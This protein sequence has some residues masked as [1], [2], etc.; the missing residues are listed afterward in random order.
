MSHT[1]GHGESASSTSSRQPVQAATEMAF[2][3]SKKT[4]W[5]TTALLFAVLIFFQF[6]GWGLIARLQAAGSGDTIY[7]S[8]SYQGSIGGVS[9]TRDDVI[10][11]DVAADSWSMYFDGSDVGVPTDADVIGFHKLA[12]G[13]L[14][15][16][17]LEDGIML[18]DVGYVD[19]SDIVRFIPT[20]LG[21]TTSGS[22]EMYFDGSDVGLTAPD[23]YEDLRAV[24]ID[25]ATG[26]IYLKP[27]WTFSVQG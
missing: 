1:I 10:F 26:N 21:D 24:W 23:D 16:T 7:L 25:P 2:L 8:T 19:G 4:V 13:S 20:S 17:F 11:Y 9:F 27:K 5:I 12:D 18:P 15:F 22:F 14:L 6:N 3:Q